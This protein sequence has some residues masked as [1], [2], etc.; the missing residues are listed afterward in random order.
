MASISGIPE[1]KLPAAGSGLDVSGL[2]TVEQGFLNFFL[3]A[4]GQVSSSISLTQLPGQGRCYIA[5]EDIAEDHD[6]FNIPRSTLL[7]TRN[8]VLPALCKKWEDDRGVAPGRADS[9]PKT[10]EDM[11]WEGEKA[12]IPQTWDELQGWSPL[13]VCMM[14]EQWRSHYGQS[15][16]QQLL[17]KAKITA[18]IDW[19]SYLD[20]MPGDFSNMPMFWSEKDL[21]EVRGTSVPEKVGREDADMEYASQVRPYIKAHARIFL[22]ADAESKSAEDIERLIDE[23]YSLTNF[24]IQGSRILS[25]SFHVKKEDQA[26]VKDGQAV[27]AGDESRDA[28]EEPDSDDEEEEEE[29]REDTADISMVPMADMLNASYASENARLFYHTS[30]LIMR[31]T[32]NIKRGE[33]ILNTYAD[34]PN[35]DLLRR[36]GYVDKWNAADEVEVDSSVLVN[37]VMQREGR[38]SATDT[39]PQTEADKQRHSDLTSRVVY[40]VSLGLEESYVLTSCFP[41]SEKPPHRPEPSNP[42][43]KE[44]KGAMSNLDEEL[45]IAVR[46]LLLTDEEFDAHQSKEKMPKPKLD[47]KIADVLL[48]ALQRRLAMYAGGPCS[49]ADE[50]LI[51]GSQAGSLSENKRNAI[52][53]RLGEKRVIENNIMVLRRLAELH[54][55]EEDRKKKTATAATAAKDVNK[56]KS[57]QDSGGNKKKSRR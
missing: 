32:R 54:K 24:H 19:K 4:G 12:S 30:A 21:E 2:D 45:L 57:A 5:N 47:D 33:Q 41:P 13:I 39:E 48:L 29:E 11:D 51:Y 49:Q 28:D 52:I 9:P 26:E 25:R 6:I 42:S 1:D 27:A 56:R 23:H 53:V 44:I 17:D 22:G 15:A 37:A 40:F 36:Y 18:E 3:K 35:A 38:M 46:A 43:D 31:A 55:A 20:I 34:P 50:E 14:W 7:N 16:V 10:D 8:S